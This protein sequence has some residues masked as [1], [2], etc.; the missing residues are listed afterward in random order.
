MCDIDCEFS[1][2]NIMTW[3]DK[4]EYLWVWSVIAIGLREFKGSEK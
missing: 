3:C 1:S 4:F 2:I